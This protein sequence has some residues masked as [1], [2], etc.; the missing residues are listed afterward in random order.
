[1]NKN[2]GKIL[3]EARILSGVSVKEI[4]DILVNKGYKI[5]RAHV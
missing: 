3:K 2:I 5:G 1:M 4:S